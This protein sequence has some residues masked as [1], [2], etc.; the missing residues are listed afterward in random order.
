MCIY[1]SILLLILIKY[2]NRIKIDINMD[3]IYL[4]ND[5]IIKVAQLS[6]NNQ[7]VS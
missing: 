2:S 7:K 1:A 6:K 4:N 3:L 5:L